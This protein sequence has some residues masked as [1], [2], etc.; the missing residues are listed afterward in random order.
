FSIILLSLLFLAPL[1]LPYMEIS[2][3]FGMRSF[4]DAFGKIPTF[5][6]YFFTSSASV[7]WGFLSHHAIHFIPEWWCHFLFVGA[8]PWLGIAFVPIVLFSKKIQ[9][10]KKKFIL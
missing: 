2:R 10:E 5:S 3:Q 1:M 8:L 7:T 4:D 6:S 9:A